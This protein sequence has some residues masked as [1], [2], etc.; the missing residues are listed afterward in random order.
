MSR[1]FQFSLRALLVT[2]LAIALALGFKTGAKHR[3]TAAIARLRA[4]GA[5]IT[6]EGPKTSRGGVVDELKSALG[7]DSGP[8]K[9]ML[10]EDATVFADEDVLL[11]G[12]VHDATDVWVS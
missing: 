4:K 12:D 5:E 6:A 2:V 3:Q 11:I 1:R 7:M 9:V 8:V 10:L